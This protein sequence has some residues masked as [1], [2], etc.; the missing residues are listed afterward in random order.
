MALVN[1][2]CTAFG[3]QASPVP[4]AARNASASR[5]WWSREPPKLDLP[6][7]V[8][9]ESSANL[10]QVVEN[11]HWSD[12]SNAASAGSASE[13]CR[14][15]RSVRT[16]S[17]VRPDCSHADW[18]SLNDSAGSVPDCVSEALSA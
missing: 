3:G 18:I 2:S 12:S 9:L 13:V 5:I 4:S 8:S 16:S 14:L 17:R 15:R 7:I 6:M 10:T 11:G 1:A